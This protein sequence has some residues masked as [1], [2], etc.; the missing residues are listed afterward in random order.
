MHNPK[1][2][3]LLAGLAASLAGAACAAEP[4]RQGFDLEVTNPPSVVEAPGGARLAYELH[5][6]NF[7][8]DALTLTAVEAVDGAS[9]ETLIKLRGEQL[10]AALWRLGPAADEKNRRTVAPGMR[11]IVYLSG[12]AG[13]DLSMLRHRVA[14][15]APDER[16]SWTI[17]GGEAPVDDRAPLKLGPPLRGGPWAAIFHPDWE[18]GHRR[19]VYAV[20]GKARIPGR[21]A[22]D[23]MRA[24][25]NASSEPSDGRGAHVLAVADARVAAAR[26]DFKQPE[27]ED[28]SIALEDGNGNYVT[29]DLG[30]GRYAFYEHLAEGVRVE[31]GDRV[32]KGEVIG[33]L[34]ATGHVTRP[35]L[36][37]HVAD[38]N[39]PLDAEGLP[40]A[41][42]DFRALGAYDSIEAFRDG[43]MWRTFSAEEADG[44]F[45]FP[46]PML[47]VE[48]PEMEN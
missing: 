18:R 2:A 4:V 15:E 33:A 7:S 14:Y 40:Y 32:K 41:L 48:F 35:H 26:G 28:A 34:G 16:E 42:V 11:A 21:F 22:V 9:G 44:D 3:A 39:S 1:G 30:D 24:R 46:S 12:P 20:D 6:T 36:H 31:V 29:L 27:D 37:F 8:R 17:E 45:A 5:M 47:V 19:V 38:A 23:W 13:D 25:E 10:E 43:E